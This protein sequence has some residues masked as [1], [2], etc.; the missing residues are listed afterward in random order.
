MS[1]ETWEILTDPLKG[2]NMISKMFL[3]GRR[4]WHKDRR[5]T[6]GK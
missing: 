3:G 1:Q 6:W 2:I 4:R 5:W